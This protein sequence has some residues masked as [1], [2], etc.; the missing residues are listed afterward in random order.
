MDLQEIVLPDGTTRKLGNNSPVAGLTKAWPIY[1]DTPSTPMVA[2]SEW[3]ARIAS[4]EPGPNFPFLLPTSDQDGVGQCNAEATASA[5][6]TTRARQGLPYVKL[7]AGDIYDRINGG[8]DNGSTL[9]DGIHEAMTN[10]IGTAAICGATVWHREWNGAPAAE[11]MKYRVLEAYLCPEFEHCFSAVFEG[12]EL[13]TGILWYNNYN[14]DQDGWLPHGR[15]IAGG[16]AI[17]GFKPVKR[18]DVYGIWHRQSWGTSWFPQFNN[19]FVIP[20][21]AYSQGGIGGWWCCR[22]VVDEGG[23]IP[24]PAAA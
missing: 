6:E 22:L 14:P 2:Q 5:V 24:A 1:G 19:C 8:S 21:T 10:G 16:H 23:V 7:S 12:F 11:R 18:G 20:Q 17:S 3:D 9:E 4:M 13:V 15:G